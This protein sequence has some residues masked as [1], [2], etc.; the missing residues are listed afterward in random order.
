[1][2]RAPRASVQPWVVVP[3]MSALFRDFSCLPAALMRSRA[4]LSSMVRMAS[5]SSFTADVSLGKCPRFLMI[6]RSWKF[7]DSMA[8]VV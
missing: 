8:L 4:R 3:S 7:N 6:F 5:Q 1:M 2:T